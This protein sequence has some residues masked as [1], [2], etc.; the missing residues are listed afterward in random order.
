M[1][2]VHIDPC[3]FLFFL[4]NWDCSKVSTCQ[5]NSLYRPKRFLH[6]PTDPLKP[7]QDNPKTEVRPLQ[8][9]SRSHSRYSRQE[10]TVNFFLKSYIQILWKEKKMLTEGKRFNTSC[11]CSVSLWS[12]IFHLSTAW[13]ICPLF[14]NEQLSGDG[15]PVRGGQGRKD[16]HTPSG[17]MPHGH[18]H[19]DY[20]SKLFV[21]MKFMPADI[22]CLNNI[23]N[24]PEPPV[25]GV[26]LNSMSVRMK[27]CIAACLAVPERLL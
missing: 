16:S 14:V 25:R 9:L 3:K 11:S 13:S 19:W 8:W 21:N 6:W 22:L 23:K 24:I 27:G 26:T 4:Q 15:A 12:I 20:N 17:L 10:K 1:W 5:N 18:T 2:A 7:K